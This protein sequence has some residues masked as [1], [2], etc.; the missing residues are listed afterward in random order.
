M[1]IYSKSD[2]INQRDHS[3]LFIP[4]YPMDEF[5]IIKIILIYPIY[6]VLNYSTQ[7]SCP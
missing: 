1:N 5:Y 2:L 6:D 3:F 4:L 7:F